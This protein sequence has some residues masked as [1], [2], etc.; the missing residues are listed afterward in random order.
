MT[1]PGLVVD[2]HH[3]PLFWV[4]AAASF[5]AYLGLLVAVSTAGLH[6][7]VPL[8][9]WLAQ[10][11]PP[12]LYALL[13]LVV[14][15]PRS[16]TSLSGA[17]LLLWTVHLLLG[18]LTEPVL[19]LLGGHG[20]SGTIWLFPPA[21]LPELLWV[22]VLLV[23]LRDLLRGGPASRSASSQPAAGRRSMPS[24]RTPPFSAPGPTGRMPVEKPVNTSVT[25]GKPVFD[26]PPMTPTRPLA[27]RRSHP[28]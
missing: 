6:L 24:P 12:L 2:S 16:A 20:P 11:A 22:P 7:D 23:P 14:V 25:V 8:P 10:T 17:T 4:I 18:M 5:L 19:A 27:P 28:W 15:R 13:V 1:R 26:K 21:P 3:R 9:W